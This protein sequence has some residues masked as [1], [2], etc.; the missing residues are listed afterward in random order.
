MRLKHIECSISGHD[1]K[2]LTQITDNVCCVF[3]IPPQVILVC[4]LH[5]MPIFKVGKEW[6]KCLEQA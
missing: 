5:I 1:I 6:W 4:V 3:S 2:E